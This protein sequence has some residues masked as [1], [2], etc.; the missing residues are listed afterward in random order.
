MNKLLLY[1]FVLISFISCQK[2]EVLLPKTNIS[3]L[4]DINDYSTVYLFFNT[5]KKDTLVKI[6]KNNTISSTNWIFHIDKRLK[7]KHIVKDL[8]KLQDKKNNSVHKKEGSINVFSYTD[9]I[10]KTLAFLPF[11]ETNYIFNDE[12]SKFYIKENADI[13]I[14]YNN[15][16]LNFKKDNTITVDGNAVEKNELIAFL[17]EFSAF[18]SEDKITLI[19]LNFDEN[20]SFNE[21]LQYKVL[22]QN[23]ISE[24]IKISPLEFIYN[25][26]KLPEC[27]CAL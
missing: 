18:T 3:I 10:S 2:E 24:K 22:L 5:D 23:L 14:S 27:N 19:H 25:E 9:T 26:K 17:K 4:K 8:K 1:F 21:Y 16:S 11:T 20:L 12:F 7:L 15:L 13:Y 6:N